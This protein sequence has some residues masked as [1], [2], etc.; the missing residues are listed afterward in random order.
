MTELE[1]IPVPITTITGNSFIPDTYDALTDHKL[2]MQDFANQLREDGLRF[3]HVWREGIT[4]DK[5]VFRIWKIGA[6]ELVPIALPF[7]VDNSD[8]KPKLQI[9][10]EALIANVK[11][12]S[13]F[14]SPFKSNK[15]KVTDDSNKLSLWVRFLQFLGLYDMPQP[16][17]LKQRI[18]TADFFKKLLPHNRITLIANIRDSLISKHYRI[19]DVDYDIKE[20]INSSLITVTV[21]SRNNNE[22]DVAAI[23]LPWYTSAQDSTKDLDIIVNHIAEQITNPTLIP[24]PINPPSGR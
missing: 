23:S 12:R 11:N 15:K 7:T 4:S 18:I 2:W 24:K 17:P 14:V 13:A 3:T 22:Q 10:S 1:P 5:I 19:T 9:I 6:E 20:D 21:S 16:A 8:N